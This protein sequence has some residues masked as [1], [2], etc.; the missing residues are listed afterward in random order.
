MNFSCPLLRGRAGL[1]CALLAFSFVLVMTASAAAQ[2]EPSRLRYTVPKDWTPI[3]DNRTFVPPSQ[4]VAV[5]FAPSEPFTGNA[6]AWAKEAWDSVAREF[7]LVS[8]PVRGTQGPFLTRFGVVRQPADG[9]TV[10]LLLH[11]LVRDGRGESVVLMAREEAHLRAHVAVLNSMLHEGTAVAGQPAPPAVDPPRDAA[12]PANRGDNANAGTRAFTLNDYEFTPPARWQVQKQPDHLLLTQGPD[13]LN[14]V[15]QILPPQP[16]SGNLEQDVDAVFAMMYPQWQYQK[17]GEHQFVLSRGVLAQGQEYWMK[18]AAMSGTSADGR[19]HLEEGVALVVKAGAQVAIIAARHRSLFAHNDCQNH[20]DTW[21]RFFNTFKIRGAP[22]ANEPGAEAAQRIIG[23]WGLM[24]SG[25]S[26]EFVFAANGHYARAGALITTST[27]SDERY[28]YLH[29]KTYA[30]EGDGSYS[31]TGNVLNL[32]KRGQ[33]PESMR[34]RFEQANHGG[35]GWKDRLWL[36]QRS[37]VG[38]NEV[39]YERKGDPPPPTPPAP[40]PDAPTVS[41]ATPP[42]APRAPASPPVTPPRTTPPAASPS[43]TLPREVAAPAAPP[44]DAPP[45]TQRLAGVFLARGP[46]SARPWILLFGGDGRIAVE[47]FQHVLS[48]PTCPP[49]AKGTYEIRDRKLTLKLENGFTRTLPI[50]LEGRDPLQ[51]QRIVLNRVVFEP[52][53]NP[54]AQMPPVSNP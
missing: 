1:R 20:Y 7:Q 44:P 42:A 22:I 37:A 24:E 39:C 30:F 4:Q 47:G 25:A 18:E 52:E 28:E 9:S 5:T 16:S 32:S 50:K 23:V 26:S 12:P 21:R 46:S 8:G 43:E 34:L 27:T 6:E 31:L 53:Q 19:Y 54:S 13:P 41:V 29:L 11:T 38:E 15:I 2:E 51:P 36:L 45:G 17:R 40:P 48:D 49:R 3:G 10:C 14:C 35:T 33:P